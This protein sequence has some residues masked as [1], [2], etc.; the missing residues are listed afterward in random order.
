MASTAGAINITT[1][2]SSSAPNLLSNAATVS[3]G[4]DY[5]TA[6]NASALS[7][8]PEQAWN[9]T[10]LGGGLAS[11]GGGASIIFPQPSW[12]TGPGVPNDGF[13]H[14]PDLSMAASANHDGYYI[15]SGGSIQ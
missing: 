14:V 3:N 2:V 5:N 6:N 10:A 12:Q 7:Y 15:Y 11:T 4:L 8:I 9:D 1:N 13:R